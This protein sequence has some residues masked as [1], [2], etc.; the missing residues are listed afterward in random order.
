MTADITY[1]GNKEKTTVIATMN[2]D[3]NKNYNVYLDGNII[4]FYERFKG[5]LEISLSIS[6]NKIHRIEIK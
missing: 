4:P 2:D 5:T 1:Y 3:E 6:D